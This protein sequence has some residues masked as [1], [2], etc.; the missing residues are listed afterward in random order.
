MQPTGR[1]LTRRTFLAIGSG[2]GVSALLMACGGANPTP[3]TTSQGASAAPA[4]SASSASAAPTNTAA[5]IATAAPAAPQ[6]APT[7][8]ASPVTTRTAVAQSVGTLRVS[9]PSKLN[10]LDPSGTNSLDS[11]T[12]TVGRHIFDQ[13]VT[14]DPK[15]GSYLPS[16]ATKWEVVD[17]Q[18]WVFTLRGDAKFHDGTQVTSADVKATLDRIVQLKGPI[19][20][21]W[22]TLTGV[23]TPDPLTAR[24]KFSAPI[25]TVLA[26]AAFLNILP[27]AKMAQE[28][29]FNKPIGS[30]PYKVVDFKPDNALT[31]EANPTHWGGPP[32]L[33]SIVFRIIP[34]VT[35]RLTAVETGG[36]DLTWTI[37]PD[38]LSK[39]KQ[40]QNLTVTPTPSYTYYFIWMNSK[41][42]PFT[43]KRVRQAM[44]YAID[45][46]SM[47]KN[48]LVGVGTRA[49]A[50]IPATVFGFA[51]Q[52]PY[53]YDPAKAKQLLTEAG[54]PQGVSVNDMHW[55]LTGGP[56]IKE[57]ADTLV[58]Y[59][60]AAGIKVKSN[61]EEPGIWLDKNVK[62]DWDMQLQTNAVLTGDADFT[63]RRLYT[64]AANRNGYANPDLDK[65]LLDAAATAD[66]A[67][68]ATL[69]AQA[70]KIIWDDAVGI[71]P[72]DLT[73]NYVASKKVV[74]FTPP[75]GGIPYLGNLTLQR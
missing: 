73:E 49:Q 40:N 75:P 36:L 63:L 55:T 29:F 47:V 56:Q 46:D 30:G 68:R 70:N 60:D 19:Q 6:I 20:P 14:K 58:A 51:P 31:L 1:I 12:L 26:S 74:G 65:A 41:R 2:G 52:T 61:L 25:G 9:H 67:Q 16:L 11:A 39:L 53:A 27:G 35:A 4:S 64:S 18:T 43:D 10:S 38:Q 54:F 42:P 23:E 69:Y 72:F 57:I 17:P 15:T 13:L 50:P 7:A 3:A 22:A 5:A 24:L 44:L 62:L 37:P 34:E 59:W 32:A 48:L 66:P 21:L 28:G 71:F 8:V 33:Q 45:V